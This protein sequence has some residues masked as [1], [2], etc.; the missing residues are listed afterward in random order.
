MED[1]TDTGDLSGIIAAHLPFL[2]RYARALTGNQMSGD[3]YAAATLEAVLQDRDTFDQALEP[4]VALFKAFHLIWASA[5]APTKSPGEDLP[6]LEAAAQDHM[7]ALTPNAREA[8]LLN[9]IEGFDHRQI[10]QIMQVE[11]GEAP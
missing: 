2:R 8:L 10:A 1:H 11:P 5:G 7:A 9:T 4:R 3:Q 6:K